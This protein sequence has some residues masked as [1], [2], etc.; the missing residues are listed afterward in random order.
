MMRTNA[1][2]HADQAR[3]HVS[4][5]CFDLTTRPLLPQL[6]VFADFENKL[7]RERQMEGIRKAKVAGRYKGRPATLDTGEIARLK[8]EGLGASAIAKRL[9]VAR[10]SVYRAIGG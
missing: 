2:L 7:R 6:G 9:N 8:A 5:P 1:S 3:R 4:Q 10:S